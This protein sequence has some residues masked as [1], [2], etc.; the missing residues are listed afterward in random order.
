MS[1]FLAT[2]LLS[3][4]FWKPTGLIPLELGTIRDTLSHTV[5]AKVLE[6]NFQALPEGF[7]LTR[8]T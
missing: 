8:K 3:V 6:A 4:V 7:E 2:K 1:C 5:P